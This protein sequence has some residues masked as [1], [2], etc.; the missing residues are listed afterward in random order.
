MNAAPWRK[1][2]SSIAEFPDKIYNQ[3]RLHSALGYLLPAEFEANHAT[4]AKRMLLRGSFL[5]EFFQASGNLSSDVVLL[6]ATL[7]GDYGC[8]PHPSSR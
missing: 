3:K 7:E 4:I 2:A 8:R 6:L 5:Y 1:R